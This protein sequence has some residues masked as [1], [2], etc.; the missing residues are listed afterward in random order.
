MYY[1]TDTH[2][3]LWYL[4]DSPKLSEKARAVFDR[5]EK[6]EAVIVIPAIVLLECIDVF[7]KKKVDYSFEDIVLRITNSN[8]F[9]F[10]E[11]NWS[12]ILETNKIKGLKDL[13][14]RIIIA[15]ARIFDAP[16]ISKDKVVRD[17]YHRTTW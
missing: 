1:I 13:H 2:T 17:F 12:L 10:S 9:I 5:C 7:D 11:I 8:N 6:G 4:T 16:L 3:F 15:T 14:D